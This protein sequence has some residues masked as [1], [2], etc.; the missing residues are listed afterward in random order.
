MEDSTEVQVDVKLLRGYVSEA[1]GIH[2]VLCSLMV[3]MVA[4]YTAEGHLDPD[5]IEHGTLLMNKL[6][7]YLVS[8]ERHLE[9]EDRT[10]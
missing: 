7:T 10:F 3:A 8:M 9:S 2:K 4:L 1:V 6:Q 5:L